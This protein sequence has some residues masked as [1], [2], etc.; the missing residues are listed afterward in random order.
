MGGRNRDREPRGLFH[1]GLLS[2]ETEKWDANWRCDRDRVRLF[3]I[4]VDGNA[5]NEMEFL[6]CRREG[7]NYKDGNPGEGEEM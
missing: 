2:T 1:G 5:P 4:N 7:D 3:F 6:R